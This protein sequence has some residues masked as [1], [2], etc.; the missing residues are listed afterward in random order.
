MPRIRRNPRQKDD[1]AASTVEASEAWPARRRHSLRRA[2]LGP[3][4]EGRRRLVAQLDQHRSLRRGLPHSRDGA[5]GL[6]FT[7]SRERNSP[8]ECSYA[9]FIADTPRSLP[10]AACSIVVRLADADLVHQFPGSPPHFLVHRLVVEFAQD[11]DRGFA[12]APL[13]QV[14]GLVVAIDPT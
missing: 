9:P 8:F 3:D 5:D 4:A 14:H 6:T 13:E 1:G 12:L 7:P 11:L 2:G 10:D